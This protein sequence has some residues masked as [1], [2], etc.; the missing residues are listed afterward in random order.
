M[1]ERDPIERLNKALEGL[2]TGDQ[3]AP[4]LEIR[5]LLAIARRLRGMPRETFRARLRVQLEERAMTVDTATRLQLRE[6]F[7]SVTPYIIVR[8]AAQFIEFVR[9]VFGAEE[10]LRV[11]AQERSRIMHAELGLDDSMIELSDGNEQYPPRPAAI[12]VY[13]RDTD[14]V[15]QRALDAG[16]TSL[17]AVE[18][19]PYG[20]RSGSVED[21]FGNHWYIATHH[22]ASHIPAGLR[23]INSYLHPVGADKLIDF[24]QQAF[25]AEEVEVYRA[26]AGG[27]V[28][29]A[30]IRLG[31]TILE[32]GEAHGPYGPM[33]AG[34]H[35]Y[36]TDVDDMY[37]RALKA[38]ATSI[39]AP[40]D[41]PYGERG[42]GL[43]DPAGNSW[44]LA[45]PLRRRE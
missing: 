8:G 25:G 18:E 28:T 43:K 31:D 32:M 42:A 35:F 13:V 19:M 44:F 45:T 34:L 17:H 37:D 20:E 21:P 11:P 4:D 36:V 1:P 2:S 3:S 7:H 30:K 16:A 14:S 6:G 41:Q 26:P 10:K 27:P 5:E 40:A 12:H 38:G 33:P 39:S 29:H 22:G 9:K 24:L 23:A 15:Y